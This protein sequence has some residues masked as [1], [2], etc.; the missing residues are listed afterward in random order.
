MTVAHLL[1]FVRRNTAVTTK[2]QS[3]HRRLIAVNAEA[4]VQN[5]AMGEDRGNERP[6][7]EVRVDTCGARFEGLARRA[8][9]LAPPFTRW[10]PRSWNLAWSDRFPAIH[11]SA[12]PTLILP[13]ARTGKPCLTRAEIRALD[14]PR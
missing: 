7:G 13:S 14:T 4:R 11:F 10:V 9:D 6:E 8:D 3:E 12:V 1:P 2:P 5:I